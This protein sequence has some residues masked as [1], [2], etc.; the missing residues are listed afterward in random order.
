ML[1]TRL[2]KYQT[3]PLKSKRCL[4][5][6]LALLMKR[7]DMTMSPQTR[8]ELDHMG[9]NLSMSF[10]QCLQKLDLHRPVEGIQDGIHLSSKRGC[11]TTETV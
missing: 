3:N 2:A 1:S 7:H 5:E 8:L 9:V 10:L 6:P 11:H 4:V